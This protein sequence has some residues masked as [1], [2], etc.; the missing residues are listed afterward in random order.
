MIT[1]WLI[2]ADLILVTLIII[3]LILWK[4]QLNF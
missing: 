3:I 1:E 4:K 2:M